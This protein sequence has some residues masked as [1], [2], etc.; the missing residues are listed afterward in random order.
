VFL[1]L[2]GLRALQDHTSLG[3]GS[4]SWAPYVIVLLVAAGLAALALSRINRR[5]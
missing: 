2:A 4:L 1:A 5:S 3:T